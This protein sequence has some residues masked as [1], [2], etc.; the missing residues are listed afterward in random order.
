MTNSPR[1]SGTGIGWLC[2]ILGIVWSATVV[3]VWGGVASYLFHSNGWVAWHGGCLILGL[4][5]GRSAV[6]MGSRSYTEREVSARW[7]D[8]FSGAIGFAFGFLLA[9][10]VIWLLVTQLT[11]M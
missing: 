8:S 5:G 2:F 3:P 9:W 6:K 11:W 1:D 10:L 7:N 4:I